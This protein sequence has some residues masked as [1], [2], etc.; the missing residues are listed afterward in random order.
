MKCASAPSKL[1]RASFLEVYEPR[2][3]STSF[4]GEPSTA[5]LAVAESRKDVKKM[6]TSCPQNDARA[7]WNRP[8]RGSGGG[9][10][11]DTGMEHAAF[12]LT[13]L[14]LIVGVLVQLRG[15]LVILSLL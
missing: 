10:D 1:Q 4:A 3:I 9:D 13:V 6:L 8:A 14:G 12:G 11:E 15:L 2:I 7:P 5:R